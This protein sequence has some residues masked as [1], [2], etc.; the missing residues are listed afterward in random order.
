MSEVLRLYPPMSVTL[1]VAARDAGP[2]EA[3]APKD[4]S[5]VLSLF[6]VNQSLGE[7]R[8]ERWA[9]EDGAAT[10]DGNYGFLSFLVGPRG[11]IGNVF[12][13]VKFR[14]LFVVVIGRF[15]FK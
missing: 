3:F 13:K 15:E 9:G 14:C 6:A 10:A 8:L 7:F 12:A 1:R 2:G 4:A 5:I 11:C